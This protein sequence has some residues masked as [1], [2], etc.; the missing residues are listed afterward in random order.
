[1][2]SFVQGIKYACRQAASPPPDASVLKFLINAFFP[3]FVSQDP[4]FPLYVHS[5]ASQEQIQQI[6]IQLPKHEADN[7]F[8]KHTS[9]FYSLSK[10][11]DSG[12]DLNKQN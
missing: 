4:E 3:S 8:E 12:Y 11:L 2:Y 9:G 7:H 1:M 5:E 10:G 6:Q